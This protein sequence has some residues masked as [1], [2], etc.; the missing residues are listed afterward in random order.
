MK[1][2]FYLTDDEARQ[3]GLKLN[4]KTGN[5][6]KAQYTITQDQYNSLENES[7]GDT[8]SLGEA[9]VLSAWNYASGKMMDIEE[10]CEFYNLP[11]EDVKSYKLVSHTGVPYYN[12]LFKETINVK[13]LNLDDALEKAFERF[14]P[15][16][17]GNAQSGVKV[18]TA[19]FQTLTYTD[20]HI[21]LDTNANGKAMYAEP[22]NADQLIKSMEQMVSELVK[23]Q[24]SNVLVVDDLGD[25]MDGYNGYTTRGGH[26]LP[27]NMT[28]EQAFDT[29]LEFKIATYHELANHFD[30]ITFNNICNDNHSGAFGYTVN[31]AFQKYVEGTRGDRLIFVNNHLSFLSHYI[32]GDVC[33]IISHGKDDSTLKFGFKPFLDAKQIEKI[34]QYIKHNNLYSQAK[35]IIF[36]K[37]DSHQCL[38]DLCGSDDFDYFNYPALSPSSQWIQN[39]FKKGRR[40]FVIED[41]TGIESTLTPIFIK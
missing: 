33:F 25:L 1:K 22:W 40:G 41:F 18:P 38:F 6:K 16:I 37:G 15:T 27:Q 12:T 11:L 34:D 3:L 26:K 5:R 35:R 8:N 20:V 32:V 29:A 31:K 21:G 9:P 24:K 7:A 30:A 10:Y 23:R 13:G 4:R 2:R 28:D 17:I 19:H 39:N 14:R 36:K